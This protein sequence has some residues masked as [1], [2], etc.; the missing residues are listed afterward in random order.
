[1]VLVLVSHTI[2][3]GDLLLSSTLLVVLE[4]EVEDLTAIKSIPVKYVLVTGVPSHVIEINLCGSS[5][6]LACDKHFVLKLAEAFASCRVYSCRRVAVQT[7][8]E[9]VAEV[10]VV[11]ALLAFLT[12]WIK[13]ITLLSCTIFH[14]LSVSI[15]Y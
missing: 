5:A 2:Q 12:E 10:A 11:A 6:L 13:V 3:I 4:I 15:G 1:M 14:T 8:A 9:T 7:L